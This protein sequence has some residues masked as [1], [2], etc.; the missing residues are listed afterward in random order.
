MNLNIGDSA[1]NFSLS[2][3]NGELHSLAQQKGKWTLVYF[4]PKDDTPGCTQE[5]C[6]IRDGW[7]QFKKAGLTVFGISTDSVKSHK[8]FAEKYELPFPILADENKQ[9]VKAFGVWGPKKFMGREFLGT[10]RW[11]FLI[12]SDGKIQKIY[13]NV[14]PSEHADEV[15]EDLEAM[16]CLWPR[17][18][19]DCR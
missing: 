12:D 6:T 13:E 14:K 9:V 19:L 5:A 18:T 1:P 11:S 7:Q 16:K 15:L 8:K 2:D 3:Q 10:K 17:M 4:Y